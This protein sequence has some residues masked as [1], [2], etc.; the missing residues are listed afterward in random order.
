MSE[1]PLQILPRGGACHGIP[2]AP[3]DGVREVHSVRSTE[4][5]PIR[6]HWGFCKQS[7]ARSQNWERARKTGGWTF[8]NF[9]HSQALTCKNW[10]RGNARLEQRKMPFMSDLLSLVMHV[11]S[12][13]DSPLPLRAVPPR[14]YRATTLIRTP[15]L[16]LRRTLYRGTSPIRKR[17]DG[18]TKGHSQARERQQGS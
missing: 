10:P 8:L 14:P 7:V 13:L 18:E 6:P 11:A 12:M 2:E 15:P 1:V 5:R 4:C 17:L 16:P 9:V 3:L